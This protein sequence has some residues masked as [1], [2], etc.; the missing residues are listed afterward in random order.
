MRFDVGIGRYSLNDDEQFTPNQVVNRR[1]A[2]LTRY[3]GRTDRPNDVTVWIP[4]SGDINL[5]VSGG[6]LSTPV[7]GSHGRQ[8]VTVTDEEVLTLATAVRP[9]PNFSRPHTWPTRSIG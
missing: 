8:D 2:M 3:E 4:L 9:G 7:S 6:Y 1:P 5:R